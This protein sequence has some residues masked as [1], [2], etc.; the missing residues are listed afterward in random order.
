MQ[1][2]IK[3][4]GIILTLLLSGCFLAESL[5]VSHPCDIAVD[6]IYIIPL[7]KK[8]LFIKRLTGGHGYSNDLK[9]NIL[10]SMFYLY[11]N[12]DNNVKYTFLA[13]VKSKD[14]ES[15]S[16]QILK[17]AALTTVGIDETKLGKYMDM[18]ST[19]L[20]N[21]FTSNYIN[22]LLIDKSPKL[23]QDNRIIHEKWEAKNAT[24]PI[25]H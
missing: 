6:K 13:K 22:Q 15:T 17:V 11:C 7:N 12:F 18:N 10:D 21:L 19:V 9:S 23:F 14:S 2:S 16:I 20:E 24:K 4:I 25:Y 8:D 5:P 1:K 3:Y